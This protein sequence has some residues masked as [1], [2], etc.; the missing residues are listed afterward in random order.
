MDNLRV[1]T[2]LMLNYREESRFFF[3]DYIS[4]QIYCA[5]ELQEINDAKL[6]DFIFR[7][8]ES[9]PIDIPELNSIDGIVS[10]IQQFRKNYQGNY[11][12]QETDE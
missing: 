2:P 10:E 7:K 9:Q 6:A 1:L 8:L 11:G 3:V 4:Q 12:D 5:K